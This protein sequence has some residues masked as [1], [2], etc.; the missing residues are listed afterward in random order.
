MPME[1]G[2]AHHHS[3]GLW[4]AASECYSLDTA[5]SLPNS[6]YMH[7]L[8]NT[9]RENRYINCTHPPP[10]F[11]ADLPKTLLIACPW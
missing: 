6:F 3:A 5:R 11:Y 10:Q 9:E 7:R 2:S 4:M 1:P 8:N